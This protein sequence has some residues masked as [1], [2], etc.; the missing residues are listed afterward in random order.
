M[1]NLTPPCGTY[2][3]V[4][5]NLEVEPEP[6]HMPESEIGPRTC[7]RNLTPPCGTYSNV[8]VNLEVQPE[9]LHMPESE[10]RALESEP[11]PVQR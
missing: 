7:M 4:A 1:R 3:K 9:P 2:S 10:I 8:A 5:L 6:R 11:G